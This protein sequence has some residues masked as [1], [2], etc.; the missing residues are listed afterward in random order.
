MRRLGPSSVSPSTGSAGSTRRKSTAG[1]SSRINAATSSSSSAAPGATTVT[2]PVP[3]RSWPSRSLILHGEVAVFEHAAVAVRMAMSAPGR[4]SRGR[5]SVGRGRAG[6]RWR[7]R[8]TL[9][10]NGGGRRHSRDLI[11]PGIHAL[12]VRDVVAPLRHPRIAHAGAEV[13]GSP[14]A[15]RCIVKLELVER[16]AAPR[17]DHDAGTTRRR[18]TRTERQRHRERRDCMP[19]HD[20]ILRRVI[21]NGTGQRRPS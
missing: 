9:P 21:L 6:V 7:D 4:G 17:Q 5:R 8:D 2:S 16:F 1:G 13:L 12:L 11:A 3:S 19:P 18:G 20:F 15:A 10:C 14:L